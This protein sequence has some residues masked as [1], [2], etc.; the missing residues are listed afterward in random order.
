M[1]SSKKLH[2]WLLHH[3]LFGSYIFAYQR[4]RAVSAR[5]KATSLILLWIS[6]LY[7]MICVVSIL[8]VK[9]LLLSIALAVSMHLL[10]LKTLTKE[11]REEIKKNSFK[12]A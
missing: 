12:D 8:W 9:V 1:R 11:M 5:A 2:K 7:S 4:Y 10:H 6:I 3:R